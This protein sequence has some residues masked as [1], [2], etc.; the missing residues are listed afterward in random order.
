MEKGKFYISEIDND[1]LKKDNCYMILDKKKI[2]DKSFYLKIGH[3]FAILIDR[4]IFSES[5]E[6]ITDKPENIFKNLKEIS[7]EEAKKITDNT[8][9]LLDKNIFRR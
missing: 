2:D 8:K 5:H 3:I 6:L 7:Y 9:A 4:V 1:F